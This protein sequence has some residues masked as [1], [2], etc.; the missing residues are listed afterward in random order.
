MDQEDGISSTAVEEWR[1]PGL[2]MLQEKDIHC[3]N[4]NSSNADN[5][6]KTATR[7]YDVRHAPVVLNANELMLKRLAKSAFELQQTESADDLNL[8]ILPNCSDEEI[9]NSLE[10]VQINEIL[11]LLNIH[12]SFLSTVSLCYYLLISSFYLISPGAAN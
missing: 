9:H 3:T 5:T 7:F 11:Y 4:N 10:N 12:N 8:S 6:R 1:L 2:S